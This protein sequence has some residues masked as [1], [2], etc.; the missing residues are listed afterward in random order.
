LPAA[1]PAI[2]GAHKQIDED[3][4]S[5]NPQSAAAVFVSAT[6][7]VAGML[8]ASESVLRR[9]NLSA[10]NREIVA[11]AY[12][13]VARNRDHIRYVANRES[14][15]A[16]KGALAYEALISFNGDESTLA[17]VDSYL[18]AVSKVRL[19]FESLK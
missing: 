17:T 14:E 11:N 1:E 6:D 4:D 18:V 15:L 10:G 3:F 7:R 19:A 8:Q 5:D 16:D 9:A 12:R 2:R 13:I